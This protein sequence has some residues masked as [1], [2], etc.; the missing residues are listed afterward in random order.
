MPTCPPNLKKNSE[1]KIYIFLF[2]FLFLFL[3]FF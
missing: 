3:F 2:L 1:Q